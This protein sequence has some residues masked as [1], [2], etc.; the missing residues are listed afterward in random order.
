MP[1]KSHPSSEASNWLNRLPLIE[2][3][4]PATCEI[5]ISQP[6]KRNQHDRNDNGPI[7]NDGKE[8]YRRKNKRTLVDQYPFVT[9]APHFND[10]M[11][12]TPNN[13]MPVENNQSTQFFGGLPVPYR[14]K[15]G[16][17]HYVMRH[18]Q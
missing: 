17:H 9:L 6:T 12:N 13:C 5:E 7:N 2:N 8:Q 16:N 1:S 18:I 10:Q 11:K 3:T 14:D 4:Y 15:C